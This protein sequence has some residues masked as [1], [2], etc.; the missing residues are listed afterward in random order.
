MRRIW[1]LLVVPVIA[2]GLGVF[3]AGCE[4]ST[5]QKDNIK[6]NKM[7]GGSTSAGK[8][9]GDKS[10]GGKMDGESTSDSKMD[11]DKMKG[12]KMDGESTGAGKMGGDKMKGDKSDGDKMKTDKMKTG[13][14][15]EAGPPQ[16]FALIQWTSR[17]HIAA[18]NY[19]Q[20]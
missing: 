9:D 4:R 18:F 6:G 17:S 11:G 8:M 2:L 10:K 5:A 14:L 20:A 12:G 19:R 1:L 7:E 15:L 3:L 13:R 16:Q